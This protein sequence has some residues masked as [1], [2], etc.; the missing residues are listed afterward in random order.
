M[1]VA[2]TCFFPLIGGKFNLLKALQPLVPPHHI[3]VEVFGGAA[4]M[5]L[6]KPP[7][8]VEVYNDIDSD[9]VNLF[10]VIRDRRK[11]FVER[12]KLILY[13]RGLYKKWFDEP[14]YSPPPPMQNQIRP[15]LTGKIIKGASTSPFN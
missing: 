15:T 14:I 1:L 11:E 3:Y 9:L 12:F 5:L 6:N 10:L 13:S 4:N 7:S 2:R 8:P